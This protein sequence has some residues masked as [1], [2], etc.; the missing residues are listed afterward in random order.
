MRRGDG[1]DQTKTRVRMY[2]NSCHLPSIVPFKFF[3][4]GK[5]TIMRMHPHPKKKT[6]P[7]TVRGDGV[8]LNVFSFFLRV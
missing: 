1:V 5:Q 4:F 8:V 7:S 3:F 2:R 6:L